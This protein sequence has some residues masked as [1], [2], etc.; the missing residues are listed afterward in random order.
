MSR[1]GD[2]MSIKAK[3]YEQYL[4]MLSPERQ[5]VFDKLIRLIKN[6]LPE[7][8]MSMEKGIPVFSLKGQ[9]IIAIAAQKMYFTLYLWTMD[10]KKKFRKEARKLNLGKGCIRFNSLKQFPGD[11]LQGIIKEAGNIK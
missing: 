5:E 4:K 2:L 11:M 1:K 7:V 10:W 6:E 3:T 8:H 9:E